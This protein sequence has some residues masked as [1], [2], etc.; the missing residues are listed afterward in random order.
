MILGIK[1]GQNDCPHTSAPRKK[2]FSDSV[3]APGCYKVHRQQNEP[4]PVKNSGS[5]ANQSENRREHYLEQRHVIIEDIAV[6]NEAARPRPDHMH[7]LRLVAVEAVAHHIQEFEYN[8]EREKTRCRDKLRL[9][10]H[11]EVIAT[12]ICKH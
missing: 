4:H 2:Q 7:V 11:A 9:P 1:A 5:V 12:A 8:H 10:G 3:S 6:L